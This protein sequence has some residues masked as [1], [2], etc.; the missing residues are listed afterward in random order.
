MLVNQKIKLN[1]Y[2]KNLYVINTEADRYYIV[3]ENSY[4]LFN[5]L[6]KSE[7]WEEALQQFKKNWNTEIDFEGFRKLVYGKFGEKGILNEEETIVTPPKRGT[8]L[9]LRQQVLNQKVS[10]VIANPFKWLFLYLPFGW[11]FASLLIF[12]VAFILIGFT[13]FYAGSIELWMAVAVFATSVFHEIGHVAACR[14]MGAKHGGIGFGFYFLF[15]VNYAELNDVWTL[16]KQDRIKV[17]LAGVFFELIYSTIFIMVYLITGR[18]ELL[19]VIVLVLFSA[20]RQLNPFFRFDGYWVLSDFIGIPNLMGH[21]REQ[22]KTSF[23]GFKDVLVQKGRGISSLKLSGKKLF[24]FG[25]GIA[26]FFISFLFISWILTRYSEDL[27]AFPGAILE[28]ITGLVSFR[29]PN[30]EITFGFLLVLVFYLLVLKLIVTYLF[31]Q[32]NS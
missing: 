29:V 26:N 32:R 4:R 3:N 19:F 7:T 13:S 17:N 30:V 15:P 8:Y 9:R 2:D 20:L 31:K 6:K 12:N 10:S 25:Y 5:L 14:A 11:V 27:Y 18:T 1:E 23:L 24:L 16:K 22:V 21:S 28:I